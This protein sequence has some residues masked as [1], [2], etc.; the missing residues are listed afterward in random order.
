MLNATPGPV[1][2]PS[3]FLSG[4]RSSHALLLP[5]KA[6]ISADARPGCYY[7]RAR[8]IAEA[9]AA[10]DARLCLLVGRAIPRAAALVAD[11]FATLRL[12]DARSSLTLYFIFVFPL[13]GLE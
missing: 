12:C 13:G 4:V 10:G 11:C 2:S 7:V 6:L 1:M 3:A 5:F 9:D 8:P